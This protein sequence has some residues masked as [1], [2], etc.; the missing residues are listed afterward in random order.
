MYQ[1]ALQE[2]ISIIIHVITVSASKTGVVGTW[3]KDGTP[4]CLLTFSANVTAAVYVRMQI[5]I[6]QYSRLSIEG[7]I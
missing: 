1:T 5:L 3:A 4:T 2:K 7:C 6:F